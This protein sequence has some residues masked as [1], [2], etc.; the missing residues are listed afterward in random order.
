MLVPAFT[1]ENSLTSSAHLAR[2]AGLDEAGAAA[3]RSRM[4]PFD[5]DVTPSQGVGAFAEVVRTT[6]GAA[7]SGHP[8]TSFAALGADADRLCAQHRTECHLGEDSPLGKLWWEGGQVLMINV[9]FSA[10]TAFHLAE[11]RIPKPPLR[12]YDC[13]VKVSLPEGPGGRPHDGKWTTYEDV[14]L[15]DSDFEEIGR[16]L[17]ESLVRRGRVGGASAVFFSVSH[18][19]DHA[20]AWMT[21][22]RR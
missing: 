2:V 16:A 13:V 18:A 17:P 20:L 6:P 10:C 4:P 19:V 8:Q 21:E 14:A 22:N 7:R 11:Y 3:F 1:A 9:G 15:D 12:T 5:P